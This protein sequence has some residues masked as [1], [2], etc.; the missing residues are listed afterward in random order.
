MTVR[1]LLDPVLIGGSLCLAIIYTLTTTVLRSRIA[2]QAAYPSIRAS[3]FYGSLIL[4][5][6]TEGSPLHDLSEVYLF[7]THMIQHMLLTYA[8]APL[9][10]AGMPPWL[11]KPLVLNRWLKPIVKRLTKPI[12]AL[13]LF[14]FSINLW[15]FPAIY[16]MQLKSNLIHHSQH[17]YFIMVAIIMWWPVMSCLKELP[18]LSYGMQSIYLFLLPVGQFLVSAILALAPEAIYQTYINAPRIYNLSPHDDQVLGGVIMKISGFLAF[19]IPL[20][21]SPF[22]MVRRK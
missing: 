4:L 2:P 14:T 16:E 12:V 13:L 20:H 21:T 11:L 8:V 1:W 19:G 6:L 9:M 18:R 17:V 22:K 15:H 10:L 7:S 5:Y 3:L